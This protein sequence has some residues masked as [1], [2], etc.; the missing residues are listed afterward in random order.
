M[1]RE[2]QKKMGKPLPVT[3]MILDST[4]GKATYAATIRAFA[5]GLPK[6]IFLRMFGLLLLRVLFVAFV[7][8]HTL[9][10]TDNMVD[11]IRKELND[12]RLFDEKAPRMYIYSEGDDMVDWRFVEEHAAEAK[13]IGYKV[14]M[15]EFGT[16]G[17]AAHVLLD[18]GRYW[19]TVQRLWA[20][21]RAS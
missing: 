17:H 8:S 15:E 7:L 16:S 12:K 1:A 6:N 2:Y 9:T 3:A 14:D 19:G 21:V 10:G 13:Q 11:R 18:A 4:P 5:V 20:M